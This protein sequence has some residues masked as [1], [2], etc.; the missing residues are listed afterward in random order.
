MKFTGRTL[1]NEHAHRKQKEGI[2][3]FSGLLCN[4]NLCI[5][6]ETECYKET[7]GSGLEN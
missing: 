6:N 5:T 1:E 3:I 4:R 2:T 7:K